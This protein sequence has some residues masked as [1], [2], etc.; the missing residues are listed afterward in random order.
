VFTLLFFDDFYLHQRTNLSRHVGQPILLR[1]G[2]LHD[3][4]VDPAWGYPTVFQDR[5]SG[6]WR[7]V[8]QGQTADGRF[9]SVVAE[10][11][12]GIHWVLPD[13]AELIPIR[14]R[15][16]PHQLFSVDRFGEWNGPY[17]DPTAVGTDAWLRALVVTPGTGTCALQSLMVTSPDGLHWSY[18][19]GV[20]AWH[21]FGADPISYMYWNPYRGSHVIAT[22]PSQRTGA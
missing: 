19:D 10:S 9:V 7:C 20:P 1:E 3:P 21:P 8:Y 15:L 5:E 14:N 22:R 12:D 16:T 17:L 4:H 6:A 2:T 18:V 11:H 13:L